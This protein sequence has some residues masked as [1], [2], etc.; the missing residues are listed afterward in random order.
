MSDKAIRMI[1][2]TAVY[3]AGILLVAKACGWLAAIG[4]MVILWGHAI[5]KHWDI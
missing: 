1:A 2:M 4:V 3:V 5:E